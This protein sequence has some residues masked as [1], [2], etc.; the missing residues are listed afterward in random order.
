MAIENEAA[1]LYFFRYDYTNYYY[2][3]RGRKSKAGFILF[4]ILCGVL[5]RGKNRRPINF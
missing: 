4:L 5:I 3:L 1:L 2:K